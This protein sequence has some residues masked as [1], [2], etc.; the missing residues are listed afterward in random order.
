MFELIALVAS[1]LVAPIGFVK[2]R[3]YVRGRLRYVDTVQKPA[4][5]FVAGL[6]ACLVAAPIVWILPIVGGGTAILFG[7]GVG[8]GVMKGAQD[9]RRAA[10]QIEG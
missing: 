1:A 3:N 7:L 5:P 8:A 10:Y 9:I 6:V 4:T 2:A